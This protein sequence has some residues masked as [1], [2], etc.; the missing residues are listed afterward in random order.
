MC[1]GAKLI[2]SGL[3]VVTFMCELDWAMGFPD[4]SSNFIFSLCICF[5]KKLTYALVQ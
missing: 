4:I 1:M 3:V 5:P 2:S